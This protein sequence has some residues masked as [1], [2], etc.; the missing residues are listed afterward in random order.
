M[1]IV[2]T[3]EKEPK[4]I[5]N[6]ILN[7]E[8]VEKSGGLFIDH[9]Q[10]KEEECIVVEVSKP[11]ENPISEDLENIRE[12]TR[13]ELILIKN[14]VDLLQEGE[15]L[16]DN[17]IKMAEK[18]NSEHLNYSWNR[19]SKTWEISTT[20]EELLMIR[21]TLILEYKQIKEEIEALEEFADEFESTETIALLKEK[22]SK[23]KNEIN[24][25]LRLIKSM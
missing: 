19:E 23:I 14:R 13:E 20:K 16:E 15:F 10:L 4:E 9:P 7:K 8:E 5:F 24:E 3:K 25:L 17:Q 22:Q 11:F 6:T 18:P 2:Y 1:I 21:K 12:M